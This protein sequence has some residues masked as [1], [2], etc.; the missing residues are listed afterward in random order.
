MLFTGLGL[1]QSAY[2]EWL[3]DF[4]IDVDIS[5]TRSVESTHGSEI[6]VFVIDDER[7]AYLGAPVGEAVYIKNRDDEVYAMTWVPDNENDGYSV[8]LSMLFAAG[9]DPKRLNGISVIETF[10]VETGQ[11]IDLTP[12]GIGKVALQTGGALPQAVDG[13]SVGGRQCGEIGASEGGA[14]Q[15]TYCCIPCNGN[16]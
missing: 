2:A 8:S 15:G 12:I 7:P 13:A 5:P 11:E 10:S 16:W 4:Q 6:M 3:D 14:P 9:E 1:C